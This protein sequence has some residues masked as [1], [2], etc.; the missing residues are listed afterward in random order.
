MSARASKPRLPQQ[1]R[2]HHIP[3]AH[4]PAGPRIPSTALTSSDR[5]GFVYAKDGRTQLGAVIAI[6]NGKWAAWGP[7]AKIG[8][9]PNQVAA[10]LAVHRATRKSKPKPATSSWEVR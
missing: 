3:K 6:A 9:Y 1:P 8:E 5:S 7:K 2:K 4:M 10:E